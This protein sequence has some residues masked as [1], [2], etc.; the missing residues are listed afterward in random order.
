MEVRSDE[1]RRTPMHSFSHRSVTIRPMGQGRKG[2]DRW[3]FATDRLAPR[4]LTLRR[5]TLRCP[6]LLATLSCLALLATVLLAS[7]PAALAAEGTGKISGTVTEASSPHNGIAH[8]EVTVYET[9]EDEF[10]VGSAITGEHGEYT[11]EGLAGGHYEI[12]F[13]P[14]FESGLNYVSQYYKDKSS[15]ATVEPVEV[16]QG[17]TTEKIDAELEVGGEIKG[18]VMAACA[19]EDFNPLK[20][21][22]VTAYE[23]GENKFPAGY[24]TTNEKG[25]YTIAGLAGGPY[26][27]EFSPGES[28]LNY[29]FQYYRD[30]SSP[31]TAEP[32]KVVQGE[33]TE[34]ID[35]ELEVG[36]V[37][38][39]TVTD[40]WTHTPLSKIY[41]VA[42]G[43]GEAFAAV[44]DT[45]ASGEYSV[46]GLANGAYKIEFID[47][48]SDPSY[49]IQYYNNEP[50]LASA[51][52]V[53]ASQ[54]S[55]T[56]GI[57]AALVR[58]AP[59]ST[60]APVASG[61]PAVGKMLSCSSGSWTGEPT[62]TFTYAWL[63]NGSAISG[64]ISSAYIVQTADQGTGLACKVTATN[65][66]G[67]AAAVSSTLTVPVAPP[68]PPPVPVI[69]LATAKILVSGDTA[70]VSLTCA[71]ANCT[72]TIELTEQIVV[73]HREGYRTISRKQTLILGR[74]SYALSAGHS[75]TILV[76]LTHTGKHALTTARHHR[77]LVSARV[78]VTGGATVRQPVVLSEVVHRRR[79]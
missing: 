64:S 75:A 14:E 77:L 73:K 78:S 35:A 29:V 70:R 26:K 58:K 68:P 21:I 20:G 46:L 11:V 5:A 18:T 57:D 55:T 36:G 60:A 62:P 12:E 56:P 27:V 51:S 76:H 30:K 63:R 1:P 79:R 8:I 53:T 74:G 7:A 32:V 38:S 17:E 44:A 23:V 3:A 65:K 24:A 47:L 61:A 41:V 71:N 2:M 19:C 45:N 34:E 50:S 10:P 16:V 39:G 9:G 67:S 6:A 72:G 48:G 33:I 37:I 13:S 15:P 22:E 25:E 42:I 59:V 54:G 52:S 49:I 4:C 43:S 69:T 40:A 66:Y 28:G 31:A